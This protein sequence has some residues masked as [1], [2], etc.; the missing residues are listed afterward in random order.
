MKQAEKI[1]DA[2]KTEIILKELMSKYERNG[3]SNVIFPELRLKI[4]Y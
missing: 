4:V 2:K 3:R 1:S